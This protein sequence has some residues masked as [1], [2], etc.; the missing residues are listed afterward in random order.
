MKKD[1][2][3]CKGARDFLPED[4]QRFRTVENIFINACRRWGFEEVRTPTL[5]YLQLFTSSGTLTPKMLNKVYSFLDWD[6]WS[7]ERVVLR[8]DGTIPVARLYMENLPQQKV[9]KLFYVTNVFSFEST[10]KENRE[11]WQCGVE[12]LGNGALQADIE[13]IMLASDIL[14]RTGISDIKLSLS[15][16]GLLKSLLST[17]ELE[18]DEYDRLVNSIK[19]GKWGQLSRARGKKAAINE[20]INLLLVAKGKSSGYPDNIKTLRSIPGKV[21]SALNDF[22]TATSSLDA[23]NCQYQIDITTIKDFEYYTGLCFKFIYNEHQTIC[24]GGRYNNLLTL[25]GGRNIPAC[26]FAIYMDPLLELVPLDCGS[27]KKATIS[28]C[29][30]ASSPASLVKG[31]SLLSVLHQNG[32]TAEIDFNQAHGN[33]RYC[34]KPGSKSSLYSVTDFV[35]NITYK[36]LTAKKIMDMLRAEG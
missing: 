33:C 6:G 31:Y 3:R 20:L 17:L 29:P 10:G 11:R 34:I 35:K 14:K 36:S 19:Q 21:L 32:F 27:S 30:S 16:T 25:M 28:V 24:S 26:G 5:E 9:A 23:L 7:G 2:M 13:L 4:M 22:S 1:S 18:A 8:P 12:Y 15:H